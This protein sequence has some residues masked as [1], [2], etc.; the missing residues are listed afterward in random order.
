MG[1]FSAAQLASPIMLEHYPPQRWSS[2][3]HRSEIDDCRVLWMESI[4]RY[5]KDMDLSSDKSEARKLKYKV[6]QYYPFQNTLYR[7]RFTLP[8]SKCLGSNQPEYVM[9]DIHEETCGK[10]YRVQSVTQKAL[11]QGYY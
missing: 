7:R 4:I 2:K 11:C 9:R 6:A 3:I 10:N 5:F 1:S 8:Y